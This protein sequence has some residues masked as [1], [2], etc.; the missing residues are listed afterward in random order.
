[1]AG[2]I[3]GHILIESTMLTI[4]EFARA[5]ILRGATAVIADRHEIIKVTGLDGLRYMLT[6]REG[7]P[8]DIFFAVVLCILDS[9]GNGAIAPGY[10]ADFILFDCFKDF[11]VCQV[12]KAGR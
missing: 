8:I 12:F 2:L 3:D 6:V 9:P 1:M 11:R 10:V 4:P 5:V 7:L